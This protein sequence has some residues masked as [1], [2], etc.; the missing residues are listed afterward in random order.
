MIIQ[1]TD[2]EQDICTN[3]TFKGL[4]MCDTCPFDVPEDERHP[5]TDD[6]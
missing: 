1:S 4:G 2:D 5:E 6:E 3:C